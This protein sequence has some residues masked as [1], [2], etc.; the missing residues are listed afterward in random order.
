MVPPFQNRLSVSVDQGKASKILSREGKFVTDTE[1]SVPT[2]YD[3]DKRYL[4]AVLR[5]NL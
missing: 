2:S 4:K 3:V 5:A 1:V